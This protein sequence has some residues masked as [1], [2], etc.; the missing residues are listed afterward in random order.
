MLDDRPCLR[1]IDA[2]AAL[3]GV[4][5]VAAARL[6]VDDATDV[7]LVLKNPILSGAVPVDGRN[8]PLS[9]GGR[10]DALR[11]QAPN[12]VEGASAGDAFAEDSADDRRLLRVDFAKAA[13]QLAPI[14]DLDDT[15][16]AVGEAAGQ[17]ASQDPALLPSAN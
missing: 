4:G 17:I 13:D 7:D 8:R 12:Y 3:A 1:V 10:G 14:V 5:R 9:A 16:V 15:P 6:P 2:D 11:V